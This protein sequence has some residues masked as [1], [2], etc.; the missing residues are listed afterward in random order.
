VKHLVVL[1]HP[2][3]LSF[4]ASVAGAYVTAV[5][6]AGGSAQL[7]NLYALQF[8]PRLPLTE[9]PFT[10]GYQIS[11]EVAAERT[12]VQEADAIALVYPL[13]LNSPPA[14]MKGY[15]ERVFGYDFGYGRGSGGNRPLLTGKKLITF[16]TSGQPTDWARRTGTMDA[17]KLL[18][19][20]HLAAMCGLQI[21]DHIH[22]GG[23]N[24][25]TR[26]DVIRGYLTTVEEK[27]TQIFG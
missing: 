26:E 13:W 25:L 22:F 11:S 6:R 27:V 23:I 20:E 1:A 15:L 12:Y 10:E 4:N 14:I 17:L 2:S 24:T 3:P 18:V 16:S 21:V 19:D 9:Y 5:N 8:D 7:R